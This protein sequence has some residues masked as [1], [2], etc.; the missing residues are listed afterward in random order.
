MKRN[1]R[2]S[3]IFLDFVSAHDFI[4]NL[5]FYITQSLTKS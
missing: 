1:L 3:D 4:A 2:V 5:C